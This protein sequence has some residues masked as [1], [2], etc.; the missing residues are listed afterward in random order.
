ME[1]IKNTES[2]KKFSGLGIVIILMGLITISPIIYF[3]IIWGL[4][5]VP[6][7]SGGIMK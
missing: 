5:D 4:G 6:T 1:I 7:V 2:N 3:L